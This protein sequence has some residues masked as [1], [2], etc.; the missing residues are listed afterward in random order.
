MKA[1]PAAA[2]QALL[3]MR[4]QCEVI[5]PPAQSTIP[6]ARSAMSAAGHCCPPAPLSAVISWEWLL[7]DALCARSAQAHLQAV[8]MSH[9]WR[10]TLHCN[11][12]LQGR[13]MPTVSC[14]V[15]RLKRG[16]SAERG[17]AGAWLAAAGC[18]AAGSCLAA[19]Q[20]Q[21]RGTFRA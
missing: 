1:T 15:S 6:N 9:D 16:S 3:P 2:G 7:A 19:A 11:R 14:F 5:C 20:W 12:I 13:C 21:R 18:S 17:H 8:V 4:Q 10:T